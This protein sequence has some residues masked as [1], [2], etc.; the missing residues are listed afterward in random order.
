VVHQTRLGV[1]IAHRLQHRVLINLVI[2]VGRL[3]SRRLRED[4]L[5]DLEHSHAILIPTGTQALEALL[6]LVF[7]S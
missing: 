4:A 6:P 5:K 7:V 3:C 2:T 1:E